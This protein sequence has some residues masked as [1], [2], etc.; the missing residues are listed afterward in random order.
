MYS[1]QFGITIL[2]FQLTIREKSKNQILPGK[3]QKGVTSKDKIIETI[4]TGN[5]IR[6]SNKKRLI[7]SKDG[8]VVIGVKQK[9]L[10]G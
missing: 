10:H 7:Q 9:G 6:E 5:I 3:F 1:R 8:K 4:N 2:Q